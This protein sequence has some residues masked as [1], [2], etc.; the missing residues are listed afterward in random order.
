MD[1]KEFDEIMK[2]YVRSK[3][4]SA[5]ECL[6]KLKAKPQPQK[7]RK[8]T[9]RIAWATFSAI[10]IVSVSLA[11]ALPLALKPKAPDGSS[12]PT[13][14][15]TPLETPDTSIVD[16]PIESRPAY[17]EGTDFSRIPLKEGETLKDTY[18]MVVDEITIESESKGTRILKAKQDK[19][20]I[21]GFSELA[22]VFNM[23]IVTISTHGVKEN[24]TLFYYAGYETLPLTVE[25]NGVTINYYTDLVG[26]DSYTHR[27]FFK[28][29]GYKYYLTV[30]CYED[31]E[32]TE[33][34]DL[35]Y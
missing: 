25:Y 16:P 20:E 3:T 14:E 5:D 34:L 32:I 19:Q 33:L 13:V 12:T 26:V 6:K 17:A 27:I 30:T 1:N 22:D 11:V 24:Y 31:V 28:K 9:P 18:G 4:P 15:S 10:L 21:F 8:C 7:R 29:N 23:G 35:I 2:A